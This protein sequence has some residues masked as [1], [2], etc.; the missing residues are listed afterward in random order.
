M[1]TRAVHAPRPPL[2]QLMRRRTAQSP[3]CYVS[4]PPTL[5]AWLR[6]IPVSRPAPHWIPRQRRRRPSPTTLRPSLPVGLLQSLTLWTH[7]PNTRWPD[8]ATAFCRSHPVTFLWLW[9][10]TDHEPHCQHVLINEMWRWTESTPRSGWWHS[11]MAGIYS[12]CTTRKI[13][14]IIRL[15]IGRC[16]RWE[17]RKLLS[18]MSMISHLLYVDAYS[19]SAIVFAK[20]I[21]V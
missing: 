2:L 11:H 5:A 1:L 16:R 6:T 4:V 14:I 15:H 7:A 18:A 13:I 19:Q 20:E 8:L 12:D 10:A 9:P 3:A 21:K 17:R